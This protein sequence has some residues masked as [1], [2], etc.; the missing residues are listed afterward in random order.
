MRIMPA[1]P[2]TLY[3]GHRLFGHLRT[4]LWHCTSPAEYRQIRAEGAIKPNDGRV[5]KWGDCKYACQELGAVS[6]FDFGTHPEVKVLNQQ[7]KWIDFLRLTG[8]FT[9]I[10]GL[11][12]ART[13]G[14]L[15]PYPEN[16]KGTSGTVIPWVEVCH[17]GPIPLS[18]ATKYLLVCQTDLSVFQVIEGELTEA[19]LGEAESEFQQRITSQGTPAGHGFFSGLANTPE[20]QARLNAARDRVTESIKSILPDREESR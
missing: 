20:V 2:S 15:I 6:L 3:E 8:P 16:K 1:G 5:K 10:I 13:P 19:R 14:K 11:D 9:V 7:M 17:C 18:A 12:R 4:G